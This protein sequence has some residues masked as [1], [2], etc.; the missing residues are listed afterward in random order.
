M[1]QQEVHRKLDLL[2]AKTSVLE[3]KV[4]ENRDV[5]QKKIEPKKEWLSDEDLEKEFFVTKGNRYKLIAAKILRKYKFKG[6]RSKS[7]YKRS[8]VEEALEKGLFFPKPK[9]QQI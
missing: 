1:E 6:E 3:S 8:E 5:I 9:T 4:D 2:L 7:L